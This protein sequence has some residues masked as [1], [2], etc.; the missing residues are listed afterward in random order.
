MKHSIRARYTQILV[1]V[2]AVVIGGI[3]LFNQ[4]FLESYVAKCKQQTVED[5]VRLVERYIDSGWGEKE[6][7]QLLR[8]CGINNITVYV[9]YI[10]EL[11]LPLLKCNTSTNWESLSQRFTTFLRG[12]DI[13]AN[14]VFKR[15]DHFILYQVYDSQMN[16]T[17]MEC[18]GG[19]D[20][21]K[22]I[23]STSLEGVRDS[24]AVTNRFLLYVGIGSV[25]LGGVLVYFVSRRLT[26]PIRQLAALSEQMAELNFDVHYESSRKDEIG[27]L[28]DS[29][30]QMS[31]RLQKTIDELKSANV[32][33]A[34]D[35]EEKNRIDELRREFLSNVSHELKTPIALIQGYSEGLKDGIAEDPESRDYYCDVIMDEARKMNHIVKRL[36]NLDEIESG[37]MEPTL[38][39]FD[40]MQL[41]RGVMQA[42]SML[43]GDRDCK[44][45]LL[46]PDHLIVWADEF[47]IEEVIQNY[48]SNAYHYVSDP[49]EILV[50][51][52]PLEAGKVRVE[53]KNTG[54]R[55]P[56]EDL[57]RIW[58]KFYKVDK[59][60][61][62][63]YGGSGIGLSI[64]KAIMNSHKGSC[65][66][67]NCEDGVIFWCEWK[68]AEPSKEKETV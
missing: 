42:S 63:S 38:E 4:F 29:M 31:A 32:R 8:S 27:A 36:L 66:A 61:T 56:E 33:L 49:G 24:V 40:L 47:M 19:T 58:D 45:K 20:R 5:T 50:Q 39:Q 43:A 57:E 62:R 1:L 11:G 35:I 13:Q 10:N 21:V 65:G 54:S 23:I 46:G 44:T 17:Q 34:A 2:I 41:L 59:A 51:A 12:G 16:S 14:K 3:I 60:R 37:Q 48:L 53:V 22:Y 6:E 9:Y 68:G 18:V 67:R 7:I 30:N 28:G 64:V 15:A 25:I 52:I 26:R 55:I